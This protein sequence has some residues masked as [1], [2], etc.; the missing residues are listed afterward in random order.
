MARGEEK[1][2]AGTLFSVASAARIIGLSA[3]HLRRLCREEK[4]DHVRR[5]GRYYFTPK[6]TDQFFT[7]VKR[8][9]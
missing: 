5:L 1:I 2:A 8:T 3:E 7:I 9:R 4:V 6:Q